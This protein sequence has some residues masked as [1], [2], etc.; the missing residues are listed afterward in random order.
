MD[1]SP[2]YL[3]DGDLINFDK[4]DTCYK[5]IEEIL[6][7]QENGY[8]GVIDENTTIA[9]FLAN[10][11]VIHNQK[12][13]V[14]ASQTCEE[15]TTVINDAQSPILPL[16][17]LPRTSVSYQKHPFRFHDTQRT[18]LEGYFNRSDLY[19]RRE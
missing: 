13:R 2:T 17:S 4:F 6:S 18:R 9:G 7:F 15:T 5:M 10:T 14:Q 8:Q 12:E 1:G 16:H 3:A 11:M 19:Q